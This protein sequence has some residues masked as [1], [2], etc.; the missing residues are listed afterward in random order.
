MPHAQLIKSYPAH[1]V[2]HL[3]P[4]CFWSPRLAPP[5]KQ[6]KNNI[7]APPTILFIT[8]LP[9]AL[10][11]TEIRIPLPITHPLA[12]HR[13]SASRLVQLIDMTNHCSSGHEFPIN[14]FSRKQLCMPSF[15]ALHPVYDGVSS[16]YRLKLA[17]RLHCLCIPVQFHFTQTYK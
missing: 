7:S 4:T 6:K 14:F 1:I 15:M 9:V 16:A 17:N 12:T 2:A 10:S 11:Q 8:T 13:L 3:A 5:I